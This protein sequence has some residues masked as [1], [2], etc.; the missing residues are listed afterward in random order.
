MPRPLAKGAGLI[1]LLLLL[2]L[3]WRVLHHYE[4]L[5]AANMMAAM[6]QV[7]QWRDAPWM[8]AA[9]MLIYAGTLVV[10]FPLSILVVVTAMLFGPWWGLGY[11]TL[12]TLTSSVVSYWVGHWLGRDALLNYG[13]K[14]LRGMTKYLTGRGIR[15]MTLVNLLP[16][17]PFTLTNMLAGA[18]HIRFRDYMIGSTLG[19][20]PGLASV[21]LLGS[22]L[23]ALY[24]A[25]SGWDV[26]M[27]VSGLTLGVAIL[28]W[29][30]RK[31]QRKIQ[32]PPQGPKP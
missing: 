26:L 3:T 25:A 32:P 22:Q 9:V 11:A 28:L 1:L 17:A 15:T 5:T 4:V 12:G 7:S 23:R 31:G 21:T 27:A 14:R 6:A 30:K 20:M 8:F 19:I 2:S 29:L 13:G 10:M 16:L 18:F 24:T